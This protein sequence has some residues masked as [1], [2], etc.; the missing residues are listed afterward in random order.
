[1]TGSESSNSN[2]RKC[3]IRPNNCQYQQQQQKE[4]KADIPT[5]QLRRLAIKNSYGN[6][7]ITSPL[8]KSLS[9]STSSLHL[10]CD[11]GP[12]NTSSVS[13]VGGNAAGDIAESKLPQLSLTFTSAET[14]QQEK[15]GKKS[16]PYITRQEL[17]HSLR[18]TSSNLCVGMT[19]TICSGNSSY[20]YHTPRH[21]TRTRYTPR[22][23][24]TRSAT[25]TPDS[26]LQSYQLGFQDKQTEVQNCDGQETQS[27]LNLPRPRPIMDEARHRRSQRG[28]HYVEAEFKEER[29]YQVSRSVCKQQLRQKSRISLCLIIVVL[30]VNFYSLIV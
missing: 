13:T 28:G 7:S 24:I 22:S 21:L 3:N 18:R 5:D 14:Q 4:A 29:H 6:K 12:L 1:M 10:L 15:N 25:I 26:R 9:S 17:L 19:Q 11:P 16:S 20:I 8:M 2:A 23:A 27:L 30:M